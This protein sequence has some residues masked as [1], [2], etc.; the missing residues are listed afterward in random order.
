MKKYFIVLV[1][2]ALL[3]AC[4]VGG[5]MNIGNGGANIGVGSAIHF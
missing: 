1:L 5:S 3:S 2:T 4:A